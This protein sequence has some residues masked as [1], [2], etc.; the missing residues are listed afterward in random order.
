MVMSTTYQVCFGIT[1]QR[2]IQSA[3]DYGDV[4]VRNNLR[5]LHN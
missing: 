4:V 3:A 1:T 2:L 5:G